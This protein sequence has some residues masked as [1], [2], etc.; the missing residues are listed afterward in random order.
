MPPGLDPFTI[1]ALGLAAGVAGFFDAIAGGGG[2]IQLPALLFA[3]PTTPLPNL[4]ATNKLS[5]AVGT[6]VA[7][8]RL[9]R[10]VR[11]DLRSLMPA[12][13]CAGAF[14]AAGATAATMVSPTVM[15]PIVL[16]LLTGALVFT[17]TKKDFGLKDRHAIKYRVAKTFLI[18]AT[19]GFYD[20]FLGPGTGGF[21][22]FGFVSLLGQSFLTGAAS[23]KV[24]NLA[25]NLAAIGLF[26]AKGLVLYQVA[27]PMALCNL[28]GGYLGSHMAIKRGSAFVRHIFTLMVG[29]VLVRLA[30]DVIRG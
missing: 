12:A 25:T 7:T 6:A 2:L 11:F 18:A 19:V 17:V 4:L 1:A 26:A 9:V 21:L 16:A 20:G 8:T 28:V 30:V 10:H 14:A 23:A 3:L 5:S 13:V 15:K 24:I 22:I 29:L 27:I